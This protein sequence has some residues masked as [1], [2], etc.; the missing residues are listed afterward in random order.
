MQL[1][2]VLCWQF[3]SADVRR[4]HVD[5]L[6]RFADAFRDVNRRVCVDTYTKYHF[7]R[8]YGRHRDAN[9]L[10]PEPL[11]SALNAM[12]AARHRGRELSHADKR[13]VFEA[14][15]LNEQDTVVGPTLDDATR[16]FDWPLIKTI[17]L[18]PR[19]AFAYFPKR[20]AF[21]FHNFA[22]KQERIQRGLAAFDLALAVGLSHV[23]ESLARYA[24]LPTEFHTG[25]AAHFRQMRQSVLAAA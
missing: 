11:L 24:I 12:H 6:A 20:T 23:E 2:Q 14:F 7:T 17:A 5:A 18:R 22:D 15:F 8:R 10:V 9:R 16:A 1:G 25:S 21:W 3:P 4:Q 19:I 13:R